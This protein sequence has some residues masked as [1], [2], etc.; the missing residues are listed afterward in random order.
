MPFLAGSLVLAA[1]S[2]A[3]TS[4]S[5][6]SGNDLKY[7]ASPQQVAGITYQPDVVLVGG[8]GSVTSVS[9]NGLLWT[10]SGSAPNVGALRPG[11]I[12]FASSL[13]VGRILAVRKSG[14][15]T[16]V[17][18]GPV[19]ITDVVR[20]G[21]FSSTTPVSLS[22][23]EA[24]SATD[25]PGAVTQLA[26][27]DAPGSTGPGA[28]PATLT[29]P[30]LHLVA[31]L[32][33]AHPGSTLPAL[34]L[35]PGP[36]G[37]PSPSPSPSPSSVGAYRFSPFCCAGGVGVHVSYDDKGLKLSATAT[38][39]LEK[40]TVSF[41]LKI[42][43]GKLVN[44]AVILHGAGG[45]GIAL[46][47][48]STTG[49]AGDVKEQHVDIPVDFSVPITAFGIPLTIGMDQVFGMAVAFT[50]HPSVFAATG[51]FK[52]SGNLGF[53]IRNGSPSVYVPHGVEATTKPTSTM[54]L[55]AIGPAA[56]ALNYQAKLSVGL[57]LLG[58]RTGVYFALAINTGLTEGAAVSGFDCRTASL[59][60]FD[61]YGVGYTIP[62]P[63]A[64]LINTFLKVFGAPPIKA[65]DG[66]ARGPF[67]VFTGSSTVPHIAACV[68]GS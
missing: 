13:G 22:S 9:A 23:P 34:A 51:K 64:A 19:N 38:L 8:S 48:T 3:T 11:K 42:V 36:G 32:A 20:D 6:L 5:R 49:L 66:F 40:P 2:G 50:S 33:A 61:E 60:I 7:G 12:L 14:S 44:A 24:Y 30:P 21:D 56:M 1:C 17:V 39:H 68:P 65:Q 35:T 67:T 47:A 54:A 37:L 45:F 52:F 25:Q 43:G 41:D 27:F 16:Q 28:G 15:D 26:A 63:V 59:A 4:A 53:G 18:L 29:T 10:I 46:T 58:F 31:D 57:G 55:E 62:K